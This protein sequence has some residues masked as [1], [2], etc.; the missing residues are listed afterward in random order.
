MFQKAKDTS[1]PQDA[2]EIMQTLENNRYQAYVVG[3]FC[4]DIAKGIKPKDVDIF[5]DASGKQILKLFP[6]GK[7]LGGLERQEKI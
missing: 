5:T 4:R 7:I 3:G 2:R 6:K 1:I